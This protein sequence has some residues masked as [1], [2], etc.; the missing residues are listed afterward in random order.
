M[1]SA[2]LQAALYWIRKEKR[3]LKGLIP[4]I[5]R[6]DPY[7]QLPPDGSVVIT[8]PVV[9]NPRPVKNVKIDTKIKPPKVKSTIS[10][11]SPAISV[12]PTEIQVA[13]V[14]GTADY[15]V[16]LAT[17]GEANA[18]SLLIEY[19]FATDES[20]VGGASHKLTV[21]GK[22]AKETKTAAGVYNITREGTSYLGPTEPFT[23][24]ISYLKVIEDGQTTV[25]ASY[26]ASTWEANPM[27]SGNVTDYTYDLEITKAGDN[28][29]TMDGHYIMLSAA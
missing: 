9:V 29:V 27:I 22:V 12:S 18:D 6:P 21:N 8:P 26:P 1:P 5:I 2:P 7:V 20:I 25:H 15:T 24:Q 10:A 23:G 19:E 16:A 4:P 11:V 3:R 13:Q 17:I 28:L 14:P